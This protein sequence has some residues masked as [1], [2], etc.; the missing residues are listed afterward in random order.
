MIG[1]E[2][3]LNTWIHGGHA[4]TSS[5]SICKRPGCGNLLPPA[6]GRGRARQFCSPACARRFHNAARRVPPPADPD[7]LAALEPLLRQAAA[8]LRAARAR[9]RHRG[10][11]P[12]TSPG[13]ATAGTRDQ[14]EALTAVIAATRAE[15]AAVR[16]EIAALRAELARRG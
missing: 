1:S 15:L 16:D 8:L 11:G 7:P 3:R 14:I 12:G 10:G 4:V 2:T 5:F 9:D 6:G 13:G